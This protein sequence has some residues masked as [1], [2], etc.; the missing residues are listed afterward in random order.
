MLGLPFF[1]FLGIATVASLGKASEAFLILKARE[2]GVALA[3]IP[4]LYFA[5]NITAALLATPFGALADRVGK[6]NTFVAGLLVF[7]AVYGA[8]AFGATP[9]TI[10][11]LFIAYG[12]YAALTEGV[13]RAIVGGFVAPEVRATAYGLYHASTGLALLPA[14]VVFGYLSQHYGSQLAFSYGAALALLAAFGFLLLRTIP[15]Q[16]PHH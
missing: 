6:R 8:F 1:L 10:W 2:V 11:A 4:I 13:G 5:F 7:A 16:Q 12:V 3:L 14:S 9:K 15:L